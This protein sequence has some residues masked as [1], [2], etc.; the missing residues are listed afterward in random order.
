MVLRSG[1]FPI[2]EMHSGAPSILGDSNPRLSSLKAGISPLVYRGP[3]RTILIPL[4]FL[5]D[6]VGK[7]F[8]RVI[9]QV[10]DSNRRC[11]MTFWHS[12]R[13]QKGLIYDGVISSVVEMANTTISGSWCT[14]RMVQS[15]P[16]TSGMPLTRIGM[17]ISVL[18][19][20]LSLQL[21]GSTDQLL[22]VDP[23]G[24]FLEFVINR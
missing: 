10:R 15:S 17:I 5:L 12:V 1:R 7:P 8:K 3:Q 9:Y 11:N 23:V 4:L 18:P 2:V 13:L 19:P 20:Y 16:W 14:K 22:R 6:I 24:S 21:F